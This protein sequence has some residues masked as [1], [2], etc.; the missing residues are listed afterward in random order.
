MRAASL[1]VT[2]IPV[3]IIAIMVWMIYGYIGD[4][5]TTMSTLL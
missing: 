5:L 3:M 2:L 4:T 1:L